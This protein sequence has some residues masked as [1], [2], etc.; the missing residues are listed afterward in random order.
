MEETK[1]ITT[2]EIGR[3]AT[4]G[5]CWLVIEDQVLDV[6]AFAQEHPGGPGSML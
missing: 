6:T 5:D 4:P 2:V 1:L 3:H